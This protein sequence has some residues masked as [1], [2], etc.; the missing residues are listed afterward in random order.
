MEDHLAYW[1]TFKLIIQIIVCVLDK[2]IQDHIITSIVNNFTS[3]LIYLK[4][5]EQYSHDMA[6]ALLAA[7]Q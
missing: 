6:M 3:G 1:F 7:N 2:M 4:F 5:R